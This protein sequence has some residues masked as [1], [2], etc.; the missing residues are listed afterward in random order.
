MSG[1]VKF[2]LAF[3]CGMVTN[4]IVP[5]HC[6]LF[7]FA[8]RYWTIML[9]LI[10]GPPSKE[11]FL[12]CLARTFW[13]AVTKLWLKMSL[14][15]GTHQWKRQRVHALNSCTHHF[16]TASKAPQVASW[17]WYRC[18]LEIKNSKGAEG[19]KFLAS[20][21]RLMLYCI[22]VL[23]RTHW[24]M[25]LALALFILRCL[26]SAALWIECRCYQLEDQSLFSEHKLVISKHAMQITATVTLSR[27]GEELSEG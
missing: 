5:S 24:E 20:V 19:A 21:L 27:N 15:A 7:F 9:F 13:D 26:N 14:N 23:G 1:L 6:S 8:R 10:F 4:S 16:F 18:S 11:K 17:I 12:A 3:V 25:I 2:F 22:T